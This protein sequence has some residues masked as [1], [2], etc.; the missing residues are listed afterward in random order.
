M[1]SW[2][3]NCVRPNRGQLR[4]TIIWNGPVPNHLRHS[5]FAGC[6]T[7][8]D[9]KITRFAHHRW[10]LSLAQAVGGGTLLAD[11]AFQGPRVLQRRAPSQIPTDEHYFIEQT[12]DGRFAVRAKRSARASAVLDTQEVVTANWTK[13]GTLD[14]T[15]QSRLNSILSDRASPVCPSHWW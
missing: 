10:E 4:R 11:K 7:R 14:S 8:G 1:Q 5:T 9:C 12:E 6:S 2:P 15:P 13:V 3:V